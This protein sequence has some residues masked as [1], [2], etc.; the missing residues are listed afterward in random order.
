LEKDEGNA[1]TEH[2]LCS[3]HHKYEEIRKISILTALHV[4]VPKEDLKEYL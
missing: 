1:K 4:G 3:V 2:S